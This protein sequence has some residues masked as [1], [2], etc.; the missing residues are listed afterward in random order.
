MIW[1]IDSHFQIFPH[2]SLIFPLSLPS[3]LIS[4]VKMEKKPVNSATRSLATQLLFLISSILYT[5]TLATSQ[6]LL[7]GFKASPSS[8]VS[9]F[10]SL[11]NDST[12]PSSLSQSFTSLLYFYMVSA[13]GGYV[14]I[15]I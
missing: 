15:I 14:F 2:D 11:L 8:S 9:S 4:Q 1:S 6:E 10:Q 5:C 13:W 7:I 3:L 12:K